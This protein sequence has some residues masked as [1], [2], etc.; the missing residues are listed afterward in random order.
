MISK[1]KVYHTSKTDDYETPDAL[2]ARLDDEFAF[3]LDPC[4]CASNAKCPIFF[5]PGD[6]GL[7]QHWFGRV[8]MNPPYSQVKRW[9][10]KL[11]EEL[12]AG[13]IELGVALVAA[14]TDTVWFQAAASLA[15]E[16]RFLRGRLTF[17]GE[18]H[19]APFPSAVLVFHLSH[20][21]REE[22]P[23]IVRFWNWKTG[24]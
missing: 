19:P 2:Y 15:R 6:D 8:Y 24:G 1:P 16:I 18:P 10:E 23:Q 12:L 21:A 13:R 3:D 11:V 20:P 7:Q 9:M 5:T 4:A 14:R 22:P 17:K